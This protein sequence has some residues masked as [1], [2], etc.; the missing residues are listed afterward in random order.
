LDRIDI[1]IEVPAVPYKE[2]T[3][4]AS[5]ATSQ[6]MRD[7]VT[8][9]RDIQR[10]RFAKSASRQNAHMSHR[11]IREHCKLD[12]AGMNLLRSTMTELGLSAR[13]HDKILRVSRTIADL[14]GSDNISSMHLSEAVNYRMLD[15]QL[16][17]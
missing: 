6:Q 5:G 17:K 8:Q 15:R 13:A 2:L 1:H 12:E 9:A 4:S 10:R 7:Q 16:W 11:Q 14:D 3:A